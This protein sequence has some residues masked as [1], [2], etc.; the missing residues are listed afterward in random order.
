MRRLIVPPNLLTQNDSTLTG[1]LHHH[2]IHVL[3]LREGEQILLLDGQG[4][5]CLARLAAIQEKQTVLERGPI[6]NTPPLPAPKLTLLYGLSRRERT[7]FVWQKATELGVDFILPV[8]AA[9]SV[10][11]PSAHEAKQ[12]RWEEIIRQA[13]RQSGRAHLPQLLP[14]V[15][16][17]TA[18]STQP[19]EALKFIACPDGESL[20]GP[21]MSGESSPPAHIIIAVGPEGGFTSEE[22]ALAQKNNFSLLGLGPLILRTE[23]A[24]LVVLAVLSTHFGRWS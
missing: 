12:K 6:V 11:R 18:I 21:P 13:A 2:L 22:I 14:L 1:N 5:Q 19:S 10:S 8:L 23:T 3:R 15:D 9:R 7:E 17:A 20:A 4:N 16:F 24:A